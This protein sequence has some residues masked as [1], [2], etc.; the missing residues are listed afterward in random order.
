MNDTE[1]D[2]RVIDLDRDAALRLLASAPFGR[3]VFM[4][5]ALPAVRPVNHLVENDETVIVRTGI[6]SKLTTAVRA[7]SAVVVTYQA[8]DI[9]PIGRLG[10]SVTVTGL[11]R[12]VT[13]PARIA[14]YERILTPW[15]DK[16]MDSVIEI[17]TTIVAG[18]RLIDCTRT[19][20]HHAP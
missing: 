15:V 17:E 10:W 1:P 9:D 18:I 8:D 14:R 19:D 13:D 20:H 11:A 3:I 4:R 5:D 16:T 7:N 12:P 2:R 6:T